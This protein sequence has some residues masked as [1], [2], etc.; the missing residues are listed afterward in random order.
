MK[1]V[2]FLED[3]GKVIGEKKQIELE[4][5][6]VWTERRQIVEA[7]SHLVMYSVLDTLKLRPSQRVEE[8]A[9]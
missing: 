2:F 8:N 1:L 9:A 3:D 7:A 4:F 5:G 6:D